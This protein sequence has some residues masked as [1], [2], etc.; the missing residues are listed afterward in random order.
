[1]DDIPGVFARHLLSRLRRALVDRPVVLLDG[2]RQVGK[3]TL[4]QTLTGTSGRRY[5][6]FDDAT[7]VAAVGS[8][9]AGF[10]A[11]LGGP[12]VLDEVQR[13]PELFLAIKAAVDRDRRPGRFLLTG[14]ANALLL[15]HLSDALVG[16][17]EIVTLWPLSQGEI[18]GV[19]EQFVDAVFAPALPRTAIATSTPLVGRV[20]AGG[21]P[22]AVLTAAPDRRQAWFTSYI[23]T[24][25]AR[26]VRELARIDTLADLPHLVG[27]IAS[28]P[29]ALLNYA[30]LARGVSLP[31]TTLKRYMA[32]L[33]TV[34]L[35]R[36]VPPWHGN[37]GKRLV[38]SPKLLLADSGLAAHLMGLDAARLRDDRTLFGPLLEGFVAM[39]IEKQLGWSHVSP[40]LFHFRSHT[41]DEVDLVLEERSGRLV[42]IEVK[43]AATV[44]SAD[45]NGLRT[46]AAAVGPRFHRG[47]VLYTGTEVV[48]FGDRLHAVPVDALW[49]WGTVGTRRG[50]GPAKRRRAR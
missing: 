48:P 35:I 45:F 36:T 30:D 1:M 5:V 9:A 20:L 31:Q 6:T 39:E 14:S 38:K 28:R 29:M 27:L 40:S 13:V 8:D 42:G 21:Y 19:E 26:D 2:A 46:L 37:L 3:T 24:L 23:T 18:A 15:S 32:L 12:V 25:L 34:F 47:V 4:V 17:M 10:L 33:Q 44:G 43:A 7:N 16:R 50:A 41:G 11:G 22:E 49:T